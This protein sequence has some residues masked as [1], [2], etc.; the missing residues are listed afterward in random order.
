MSFAMEKA[1]VEVLSVGH[2]SE[3]AAGDEQRRGSDKGI[4][5]QRPTPNLALVRHHER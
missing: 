4:Q 2:G 3:V 1:V 5:H